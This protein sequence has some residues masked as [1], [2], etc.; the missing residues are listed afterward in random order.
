MRSENK[1]GLRALCAA[2]CLFVSGQSA[3]AGTLV[4]DNFTFPKSGDVTVVVFRPNVQ[5]GSL[6]VGGLDDANAD[7]TKAARDNIQKA[8]EAAGEVRSYHVK[9]LGDADGADG[10]LLNDYRGLFEAVAGEAFQHSIVGNHLPTK[11]VKPAALSAGSG[12]Q[13]ALVSNTGG[14]SKEYR[15]DWTLGDQAQRLK[16]VTGGDYA[17]FFFSH[18]AYG[19][20]GRKA[21]QLL[22]AGLLGTYIPAG[23]HA[24]YAGLVDLSSGN[25]VWLNFNPMMGGDVRTADGAQKRVRELLAGFPARDVSEAGPKA[26]IAPAAAAAPMPALSVK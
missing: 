17:L 15:L 11:I 16:A 19:D 23:I 24:G 5:V 12:A 7:W 22:A 26:A 8:M 20:A 3:W 18:D 6:H 9:F 4:R 21:A 2:L 1:V 25:I 10:D 13:T 14:S